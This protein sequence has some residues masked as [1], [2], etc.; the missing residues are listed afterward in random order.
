MKKI[1]LSILAV[2]FV[3]TGAQVASADHT[4]N[5]FT[6][7][8]TI[9]ARGA[10]VV[11]LQ[12]ILEEESLLTVPAGVSKGFFGPLTQAAV[13]RYQ[14]QSSISPA[15]GFFG[16]IT[17]AYVNVNVIGAA[18]FNGAQEP[19]TDTKAANLR[20]LL[21]AQLREHVALGIETLRLAYDGHA[22]F[23]AAVAELDD[24]SVALAASVG[25]VYGAE[26]EA[27]FLAVWREHIGFFADYT[28]GLAT[29][30]EAK[31]AQAVADLNG[32]AQTAGAFFSGVNPNLPASAVEALAKEHGMLVRASLDAYAAGNYELSFEKSHEAYEQVSKIADALAGGIVAQFPG[33]FR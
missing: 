6:R 18:R 33:N 12:T 31:K 26:A 28:T 32:Y 24:N 16:P 1:G 25:S 19:R 17:R 29:N 8:L 14:A 22:G 3:V 2:A 27:Q 5:S 21:N 11:A 9:G 13:A 30:D 20:A 10:D 23:N 15:V 7:D 4:S